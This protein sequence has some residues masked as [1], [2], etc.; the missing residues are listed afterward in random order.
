[1]NSE[2]SLLECYGNQDWRLDNLYFITNAKGE[3]V[4]FKMNGSQRKFFAEMDYRNIL[5]KSRQIGF[6]TF[7]Q[8]LILDAAVFCPN[9]SAAVIAQTQEIAETIFSQKIKF[10]YD[11]LPEA[12]K[13]QISC[14]RSNQ[15]EIHLSNGSSIKV[16]TSLRGGT[17]QY[18]HI[19]EFGKTCAKYPEKAREI[20]TGALNTIA[21]GQVAFIESTAEGQE[22]RFYDMCQSAMSKKRTNERLTELDWKFHFFSWWEE[23][24]YKIN[25]EGVIIPPS[26][27]KY[28]DDLRAIH[29]INL[30]DDQ[31]AWY[32]KQFET[33]QD[34]MKREYPSYPEEAFEQS[35]EGAYYAREFAYLEDRG[36]I[37]NVPWDP[38]L[39]VETWWDLGYNDDTV[40]WFVQRHNTEIRLID[41]YSNNNESLAHYYGIIK[42]KPYR[43]S[44][45]IG[46]HDSNQH[47]YSTGLTRKEVAY[48]L[49]MRQWEAAPK[50]DLLEGIDAVRNILP[51]CYFDKQNCADGVKLM[52]QYRKD[53]ND[54]LGVYSSRPRH[55]KSSHAAD[56]FRT[57]AVAPEPSRPSGKPIN[58]PNWGVV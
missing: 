30:T 37:T 54:K 18:L 20:V 16:G 9:T 36:Q 25:A 35:I 55:D 46:P 48:D 53:W 24:R 21:P 10:A 52:R 31:K 11:R 23:P 28:F 29:R 47:E 49:G 43:Y 44:R 13:Q 51:R 15:T 40:I 56:A 2:N 12:I 1:M 38:K 7:I 34:D 14:V 5:L 32:T 26:L 45:H 4:L 50:L 8:I 57:G 19:S 27:H 17:L 6:T 41:Y 42:N 3:V 33:Q 39:D 22:G 58:T